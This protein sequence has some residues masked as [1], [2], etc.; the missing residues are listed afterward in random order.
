MVRI[1]KF[2][3]QKTFSAI[4][5]DGEVQAFYVKRFSFERSD[6]IATP[7]ISDAKGSYLVAITDDRYPQLEIT[8]GGKNE[9]RPA[10]RMD[11][12][13]FIGKKGFKAKGKRI[14]YYQVAEVKFIEPLQ[15]Q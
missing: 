12:E 2:D 9:G 6:S 10:E 1:E 7:F 15:K 5:Y 13:E 14:T 11:V 3:A 4:Y 8:F